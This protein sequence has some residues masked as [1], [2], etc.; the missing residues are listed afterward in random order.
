M[1]GIGGLHRDMHALP[2]SMAPAAADPVDR[3]LDT[4]TATTS[5]YVGQETDD[6]EP[7][8]LPKGMT[9][10]QVDLLQQQLRNLMAEQT[11]TS[12]TTDRPLTTTYTLSNMMTKRL[13]RKNAIKATSLGLG[14]DPGA[15][16]PEAGFVPIYGGGPLSGHAVPDLAFSV[17]DEGQEEPFSQ[18]GDDDGLV[19]DEYYYDDYPF[20]EG[21]GDD[22][23]QQQRP[24]LGEED[25]LRRGSSYVRGGENHG[26]AEGEGGFGSNAGLERVPTTAKASDCGITGM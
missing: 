26:V 21:G 18:G 17:L 16:K 20:V 8:S 4:T 13:K 23:I 6:Y 24:R 12:T 11:S 25:S 22:V 7:S 3:K 19:E 14:F 15:V 2:S 5:S 1:N 10:E 9:P